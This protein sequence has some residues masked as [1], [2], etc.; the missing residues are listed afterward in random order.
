MAGLNIVKSVEHFTSSFTGTATTDTMTSGQNYENCV[1]FFT[2]YNSSDMSGYLDRYFVDVSVSSG[3][4]SYTRDNGT[5]TKYYNVDLVEF[6]ST[7]INVKQGSFSILDTTSSTNVTVSGVSDVSKSFLIFYY[8][9]SATNRCH[10]DHYV[11]GRLTSNTNIEFVRGGTSGLIDGHYYI[12]ED[13]GDN[14]EVEHSTFTMSNGA[15]SYQHEILPPTE[16][17]D[18]ASFGSYYRTS[19]D[20]NPQHHAVRFYLASTFPYWVTRAGNNGD[21]YIAL[22]LVRF[23]IPNTVRMVQHRNATLDSSTTSYTWD[24]SNVNLYTSSV[25]NPCLLGTNYTNTSSSS[26]NERWNA[27]ASFINNGTEVSIQRGN[28]G[29]TCAYSFEVIDWSCYATYSGGDQDPKLPVLSDINSMVRSIEYVSYDLTDTMGTISLTKGQ[30][31]DNC[32]PFL[33]F[34]TSQN[35][36]DRMFVDVYPTEGFRFR[37]N[38]P[39]PSGNCYVR[40]YVIEFEPD[41]VRVQQGSFYTSGQSDTV[42]ISGVN[43]NKTAMTFYYTTN[44]ANNGAENAWM[45]G[46]F[47][48]DTSAEFYRDGTGGMI[49]GHYYIFEALDDQFTVQYATGTIPNGQYSSYI[50]LSNTA[51]TE[52]SVVMC[53]WYYDNTDENPQH[54]TCRGKLWNR[55]RFYIGRANNSRT[56]YYSAFVITFKPNGDNV[57]CQNDYISISA[58]NHSVD[59]N[60]TYDVNL[61]TSIVLHPSPYSVGYYLGGSAADYDSNWAYWTLTNSGT[62][63]GWRYATTNE[64]RHTPQVIDFVGHENPVYEAEP[65]SNN[66]LIKSFETIEYNMDGYYEEIVPTKGQNLDNCVP[67]MTYCSSNTGGYQ[68]RVKPEVWFENGRIKFRCASDVGLRYIMMYLIEFN[69]ARVKIQQGEFYMLGTASTTVTIESINTNKT[70][71]YYT[72]HCD[73]SNREWYRHL[74]RGRFTSDTEITFD[75]GT[76]A[77]LIYGHYWAVECL[78]DTWSVVPYTFT[79]SNGHSGYSK[80]F[81]LQGNK[82]RAEKIMVISN[83]RRTSNNDQNPQHSTYRGYVQ[84]QPPDGYYVVD[85]CSTNANMYHVAYIITFNEDE[86]IT[87]QHRYQVELTGTTYDITYDLDDPVDVS[88][89]M[90]INPLVPGTA[91]NDSSSTSCIEKSWHKYKI[92]ND[93]TKVQCTTCNP[94]SCNTYGAY[95]VVQWPKPWKYFFEGYVYEEGTPVS[96]EI[97]VFRRDTNELI[98]TTM[99]SGNGYYYIETTYSGLHYIIAKDSDEGSTYNLARLDWMTPEEIT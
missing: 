97:L 44:N 61:D 31:L 73:T 86:D 89:S 47:T 22:Q 96:R 2:G 76:S 15:T 26:E 98:G 75:R 92:I 23:N 95:T 11:R 5:S 55:R 17:F 12:V 53:S 39:D 14:F 69:P 60:L 68:Y 57:L 87:T 9:S 93:G 20:D 78:D 40:G 30:I 58:G 27:R 41:Q 18:V 51:P 25:H 82:Q 70:F 38:R 29:N 50:N 66:S 4:I 59:W 7:K 35:D 84:I 99:S 34:A 46:R 67:F 28:T 85:R 52:Q 45:R 72:W 65:I 10:R 13:L 33:T 16:Y 24:I 21:C 74:V 94:G 91:R 79:D 6:D 1:P 63:T 64:T 83:F 43:R 37:L 48:S 54:N 49:S 8:Q 32:V 88:R 71:L 19:T 62:V 36:N 90:V 80:N 81:E 3:T 42:T 77:S 56:I